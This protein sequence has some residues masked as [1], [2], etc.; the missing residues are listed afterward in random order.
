MLS[1]AAADQSIHYRGRSIP[2]VTG[3]TPLGHAMACL[4]ML[5]LSYNVPFRRDVLERAARHA[6]GATA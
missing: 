5:A 2:V 1:P 4:E 3:S 6:I